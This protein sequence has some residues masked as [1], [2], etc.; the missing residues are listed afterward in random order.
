MTQQQD[1]PE[2]KKTQNRQDRFL[3]QGDQ[4]QTFSP[5]EAEI[6]RQQ[7]KALKDRLDKKS[8]NKN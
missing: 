7:S 6:L 5:E 4:M 8:Q 1:G 2:P 3:I